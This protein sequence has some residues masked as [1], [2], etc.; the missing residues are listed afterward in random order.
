MQIA[1]REARPYVLMPFAAGVGLI[2]ARVRRAGWAAVGAAAVAALFFR[3]PEREPR[4]DPQL[5]FAAADGV[6]T[7]VEP[8]V[9]EPWLPGGA[10]SISTFLSVHNV[11]VNRSPVAGRITRTQ[12][13]SGGFA[14][15]L[16][17]RSDAN[18]Q[19][20]LAIDG[21]MGRVVV[22]QIAGMLAR[23]ISTWVRAGDNVAAGQR[24]GII[25]FGSRTDV[26]L[27]VDRAEVLVHVGQR[28]LAGATP[29][30]RYRQPAASS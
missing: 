10:L 19:R 14:P 25:H 20:R 13:V 9:D 16:F 17:A 18:L 2:T 22:V 8:R 21:A 1:W 5:V 29:L 23:R 11:H 24:I 30:A 6:V 26:L 28:V 15:A 12:E 7:R 3:D 27:P 4:A